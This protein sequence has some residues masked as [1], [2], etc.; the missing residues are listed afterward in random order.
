L[1]AVPSIGRASRVERGAA[2]GAD[3]AS[4]LYERYSGPVFGYCLNQLGSREEAEDAVQT[5]FMNAFR[6]LARGIVPEAEQAWIFKIAH[7]VCLSRRR[8]SWR[9][10]R[11]EAPNNLEV[12]QEIVPARE[13]VADELI[14]LQDVLEQMPENQRRAI[15]LREWQGLSYREVADELELSQA[16]VETLL[17]RARRS[18]AAGLEESPAR[19][20]LRKRLRRGAD[21][22]GILAFVKALFGGGGAAAVKVVAAFALA[23][24]AVATTAADHMS[25][26][27]HA[28]RPSVVP[29]GAVQQQGPLTRSVVGGASVSAAHAAASAWPRHHAV[30]QPVA[31]GRASGPP[32]PTQS[33][34]SDATPDAPATAAP[35][36]DMQTTPAPGAASSRGGSVAP[37]T[38]KPRRAAPSSKPP[39]EK[40]KKTKPGTPASAPP[41][42]PADDAKPGKGNGAQPGSPSSPDTPAAD[43]PSAAGKGKPDADASGN[44]NGNGPPPTSPGQSGETHGNGN[45]NGRDK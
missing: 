41:S 26:Q 44:D 14:R 43:A 2:P 17:F 12:L 32:A 1:A 19:G 13:K 40:A 21:V 20:S 8:S 6:G 29:S 35:T 25:S 22:G 23:G 38:T 37:T 27:H 18:L 45:A 31:H 11:V 33:V 36:G 15:L 7:N 3:A 24:A 34:S 9:R 5:T 28:R 42:Q 10:R 16:A 30:P 39:K 4:E